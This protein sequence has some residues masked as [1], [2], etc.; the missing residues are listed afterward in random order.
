MVQLV[1]V[2]FV[3]LFAGAYVGAFRGFFAALVDTLRERAFAQY[4][5][6]AAKPMAL[7]AVSR[8]E[9]KA[10][11]SKRDLA[12]ALYAE[13]QSMFAA[14]N[15][16]ASQVGDSLRKSGSRVRFG[17]FRRLQQRVSA[18][19][20]S[21]VLTVA[22]L[23]AG[24]PTRAELVNYYETL[25]VERLDEALAESVYGLFAAQRL[26]VMILALLTAS[27][28]YAIALLTTP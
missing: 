9:G 2:P 7:G 22:L 14:S 19:I 11:A 16:R 23:P 10:S 8:L 24:D 5:Y 3:F 21:R 4:L 15:A 13:G 26:V 12:R 6:V 25:G 18:S 27:A 17:I 1:L 28:P 20:F